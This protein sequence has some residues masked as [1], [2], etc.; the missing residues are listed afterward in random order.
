LAGDREPKGR[1][2]SG[3]NQEEIIQKW[4]NNQKIRVANEIEELLADA[5]ER[6]MSYQEAREWVIE[7]L[8]SEIYHSKD[9]PVEVKKTLTTNF[10]LKI[11][12]NMVDHEI[13]NRRKL[14]HDGIKAIREGG[15]TPEEKEERVKELKEELL[16]KHVWAKDEWERLEKKYIEEEEAGVKKRKREK[17]KEWKKKDKKKKISLGKHFSSNYSKVFGSIILLII[18]IALASIL[19]VPWFVVAFI[20]WVVYLVLPAPRDDYNPIKKKLENIEK[21]L[22]NGDISAGEAEALSKTEAVIADIIEKEG[23]KELLKYRGKLYGKYLFRWLG[24][25]FFAIAFAVSPFLK[26]VAIVVALIAYFMA[27]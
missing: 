24:L 26:P 10:G 4:A 3:K 5:H 1:E 23:K 2:E 27:E 18:G 12:A 7:Q 13:G 11:I 6:G 21:R 17:E 9:T 20:C 25:A 19:G 8:R 14:W 16:G 22:K 15:G